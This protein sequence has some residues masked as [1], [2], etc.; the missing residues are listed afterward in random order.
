M[1]GPKQPTP[2]E[3]RKPDGGGPPPIQYG[4]CNNKAGC[5]LAYTGELIRYA[6]D[7]RCPECGQPLVAPPGPTRRLAS[8]YNRLVLKW[9]EKWSIFQRRIAAIPPP[10]ADTSRHLGESTGK[11]PTPPPLPRNIANRYQLLEEL[12]RGAVTKIF[13]AKDLALG[14]DVALKRFE[15]VSDKPLLARIQREANIFGKLN[16]PNIVHLYDVFIESRDLYLVLE[17]VRGDNLASKI[18]SGTLVMPDILHFTIAIFE[19]L[20]YLHSL[21]I[22]HRDIKP[23]NLLVRSSDN[24]LVLTDF[25]TGKEVLEDAPEDEGITQ[26]FIGTPRY[27]SPEQ[28][29]EA[30]PTPATD[31]YSAGTVL[32]E[33]LT[34]E[35]LRK[36][37][38]AARKGVSPE[39]IDHVRNLRPATPVALLTLLKSTLSVDP[40]LRPEAAKA[41]DIVKNIVSKTD[42]GTLRKLDKGI[43]AQEPSA[44]PS[45][46]IDETATMMYTSSAAKPSGYFAN[47]SFRVEAYEKSVAFFRSHLD[48]DYKSLLNQARLAFGLW[49][50][51]SGIAF[52]VL[53][54]GIVLL[55]RGSTMDGAITLASESLIM[56]IQQVF[57][58]REDFYR[59]EANE[60]HRHLQMGSAWTLAVQ[61]ID[62]I[63][64]AKL[65]EEKLGTLIDALI[66][67]LK[68]REE[69]HPK[70]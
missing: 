24:H 68:A 18:R 43:P 59:A 42:L 56:F 17:F 21:N 22:I 4:V 13:L 5:S 54:A 31:I 48:E 45:T 1:A 23:S 34:G 29:E 40:A 20:S 53:V 70:N 36:S 7:A 32:Y 63:T 37:Y 69:D 10:E 44:A 30:K 3:T 66:P 47:E 14:R 41:L 6:G 19:A 55:Y 52:A 58:Q 49:I 33:M 57:K 9:G 50:G 61:S 11:T 28:L 26:G 8:R 16:H 2:P 39:I 35:P 67:V 12:G 65:R 46:W 60:K 64:D 38:A 62:A 51:S 15:N 27:A 25:T